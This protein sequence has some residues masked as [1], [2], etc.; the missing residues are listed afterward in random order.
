MGTFVGNCVTMFILEESIS[1]LL[2]IVSNF[3][4]KFDTR[5]FHIILNGSVTAKYFIPFTI[6]QSPVLADS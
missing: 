1:Q 2:A 4:G 3:V 6:T 5:I